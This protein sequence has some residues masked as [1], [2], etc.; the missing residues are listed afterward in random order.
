MKYEDRNG[1]FVGCVRNGSADGCVCSC[2]DNN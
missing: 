2:G 1:V